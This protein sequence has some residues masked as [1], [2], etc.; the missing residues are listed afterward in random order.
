MIQR[1]SQHKNRSSEKY[2]LLT[3]ATGLVGRYLLRDLL[4]A[5]QRVAVVVRPDRKSTA[6]ERIEAV[7]QHWESEA[8]RALPR[9]IVLT[10]DVREKNIGLN[11]VDL[12]WLRASCNRIVH[13]AATLQFFGDRQSDPWHTNVEGTKNVVA[14]C[15]DFSVDQFHYLST[16]YVCGHRLGRIHE[17]DLDAGQSFRNDYEH[18]KFVAETFV[19]NNCSAETSNRIPSGRCGRR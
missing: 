2:L 13:A 6:R 10:G 18:S 19:R 5:G 3:G 8:G 9:P 12:C 15:D 7:M 11:S 1:L 17:N 4:A 16:A 14:L